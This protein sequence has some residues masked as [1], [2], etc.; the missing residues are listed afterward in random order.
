[1][2]VVIYYKYSI[3]LIFEQA[4]SLLLPQR[5]C[6]KYQKYVNVKIVFVKKIERLNSMLVNP[7]D[8]FLHL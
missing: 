4:V 5:N 6:Q 2:V 1:M 8:R 3:L 7:N